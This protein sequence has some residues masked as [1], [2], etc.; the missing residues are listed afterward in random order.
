[1]P[2]PSSLPSARLLFEEPV[3]RLFLLSS[4]LTAIASVFDK[5]AILGTVNGDAALV[6]LAENLIMSI[7]L[8][9]FVVQ[10]K[11]DWKGQF[12]AHW[13][14]LLGAGL[15]Y[16]SMSFLVFKG[17]AEAPIAL[18]SGV[19]QLQVLFVLLLSWL[20]FGDKPARSMWLATALMM[21]GVVLVKVG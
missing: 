1:M 9:G 16:A 21:I 18:V 8:A 10:T 6:L 19:K 15:I 11:K 12:V 17:F 4:F 5:T 20:I 2:D 3:S 13:Q 7:L 14:W